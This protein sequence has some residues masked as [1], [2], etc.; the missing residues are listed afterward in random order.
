MNSVELLL[1][2]L[3][4]FVALLVILVLGSRRIARQFLYARRASLRK[5]MITA[6]RERRAAK[7]RLIQASRMIAG[8]AGDLTHRQEIMR[9]N[10]GLECDEIQKEAKHRAE[11]IVSTA[12]RQMQEEQVKS[13]RMLKQGLLREAHDRVRQILQRGLREEVHERLMKQG[14]QEMSM[15]S[16]KTL[17]PTYAQG[18]R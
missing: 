11:G 17:R 14:M 8:L 15:L 5:Q 13:A 16:E 10:L 12:N 3:L 4:N 9:S 18:D 1:L 6:T 2:G 7:L